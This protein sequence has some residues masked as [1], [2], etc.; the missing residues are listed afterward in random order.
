MKVHKK[1]GK[2]YI[3]TA[4]GALTLKENYDEIQ[5]VFDFLCPLINENV[6]NIVWEL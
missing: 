5:E 3:M 6:E 2:E 4:D 1:D